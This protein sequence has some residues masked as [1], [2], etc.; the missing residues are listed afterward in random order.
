MISAGS[1]PVAFH[2]GVAIKNMVLTREAEKLGAIP[3]FITVDSDEIKGETVP[4]P[5]EKDGVITSVENRLFE[6]TGKR[7]EI[8]KPA[9]FLRSAKRKTSGHSQ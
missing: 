6:A 1:Q 8:A 5:Q 3:L 2:P 4:T 7:F 9:P